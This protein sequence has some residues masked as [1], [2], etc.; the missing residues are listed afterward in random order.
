VRR[1]FTEKRLLT[2]NTWTYDTGN[3]D[4]GAAMKLIIQIPCYNE[5]ESLPITLSA[6]PKTIDGIDQI[7]TLVIDDGS[8]DNTLAVA[9][10]AGVDHLVS[11]PKNRGLARA[12]MAGI[13][14]SLA[15][16]ADII[17]NTDADNQYRADDIPLLLVPI[18][19]GTA[20]F[21]VGERPISETEHFSPLKKSLQRLGSWVVRVASK[22]EIP[23]APSGFR[24]ISR[25]AAKRLHVFSEYTY[26]LETIIQ[27][28]QKGFAVAS[29]PIRTNED[30]RTSRLVKSIRA[31]VVRSMST[32]IRVFMTY[33]P[34][35]FFAVPGFTC[36]IVG[37]L[38]GI[39]FIYFYAIGEGDGHIQSVIL[40]GILMT[41]GFLMS[42]IGLVADLISVNR[43]LLEEID[44]RVK[45]I[46]EHI[47]NS[48]PDRE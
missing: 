38:I 9:H 35:R 22:T 3:L 1:R 5:E 15:A 13:E 39:R 31:Y 28:G 34:F 18:L 25:E 40:S 44:W 43:K 16:G 11:F 23:D 10:R 21:V 37:F 30:L 42:V 32:T 4:A 7:E 48:N 46:E 36:F 29:V 8:T 2:S 47:R 45:N 12:F 26:T 17:V 14:K 33:K 6:L 27:A 20:D 24:A 41:T 19:E